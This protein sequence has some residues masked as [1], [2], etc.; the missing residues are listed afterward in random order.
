MLKWEGGIVSDVGGISWKL[1]CRG[2]LL[3]YLSEREA[4]EGAPNTLSA[5]CK[6]PNF[7]P[8]ALSLCAY[9]LLSRVLF[10]PLTMLST[11]C[12]ERH[13][14]SGLKVVFFYS[15][16]SL[17]ILWWTGKVDNTRFPGVRKVFFSSF[18][19]LGESFFLLKL[20]G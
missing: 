15:P 18:G 9:P 11:R 5:P 8:G 13:P 3:F 20:C 1:K 12:D 10:I 14:I 2:Y 19:V 6:L 4:G 16:Q 17:V 7:V